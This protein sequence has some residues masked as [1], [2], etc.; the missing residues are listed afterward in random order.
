VLEI[1]EEPELEDPVELELEL[2][3]SELGVLGVLGVELGVSTTGLT[4]GTISVAGATSSVGTGMLSAVG[5]AGAVGVKSR[6]L[7]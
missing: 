1:P 3:V 5:V 6:A 7:D 4:T 2:E